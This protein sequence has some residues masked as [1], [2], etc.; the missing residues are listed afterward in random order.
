MNPSATDLLSH[1]EQDYIKTIYMQ[2]RG[3]QPAGTAALASALQI[4][5]ASVSGMLQKLAEAEPALIVYQKHRGVSLT[6]E[7]EAAALQIIR[8]HRLI[9]QFL[10]DVLE[11]PLDR[12]HAEAE[13]LEH[14]VSDYFVERL[15]RLL[16][17]PG[18]DPHGEPIPDQDLTITDL[19]TLAPLSELA[20][21]EQG[22]VRL[23]GDPSRELLQYLQS[24]GIRPGI[25][26]RVTQRNP[27]DGTQQIEIL[28]GGQPQVI[29]KSIG[30]NIRVERC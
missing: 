24:I 6:E 9:E 5:P 17:E 2:T 29:G 28:P 4:R 22:A 8:R 25:A 19:R 10:Y 7:G 27:V 14:A 23:I 13:V 11:Y 15:A 16:R 30:D 1:S 21:G 18:F 26:L 3:G 20:P 12:I